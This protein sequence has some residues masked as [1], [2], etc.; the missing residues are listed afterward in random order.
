MRHLNDFDSFDLSP[1]RNCMVKF[2]TLWWW[3]R[4]RF[5][6]LPV[7]RFCELFGCWTV[8]LFRLCEQE[9][10][11]QHWLFASGQWKEE[12]FCFDLLTSFSASFSSVSFSLTLTTN[13][14]LISSSFFC[15]SARCSDLFCSYVSCK[16]WIK[17]RC[18]LNAR[19]LCRTSG[20]GVAV[21]R[22]VSYTK[23]MTV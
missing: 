4:E 23:A 18:E 11:Q 17:T 15:S 5:L 6:T 8:R 2:R 7:G 3:R 19:R 9:N 1:W 10:K 21:P 20:E 16:L 22:G 13:I 12:A 14:C